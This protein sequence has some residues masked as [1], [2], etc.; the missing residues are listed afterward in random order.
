MVPAPAAGDALAN[1][2]LSAAGAWA[3]P[4][5]ASGSGATNLSITAT[6]DNV[7]IGSSSGTGVTIPAATSTAAGVLD[8]ARAA[9]IDGLAAVAASGSYTDL[10]NKPAKYDCGDTQR[11]WPGRISS[12]PSGGP[13]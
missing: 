13:E 5:G 1:K 9:K 3:T 11:G 6:S 4:P 12:G 2:F 8:A 10:A 7:G